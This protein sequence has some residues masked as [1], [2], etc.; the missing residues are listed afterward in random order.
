MKLAICFLKPYNDIPSDP[1]LWYVC[2]S[3]EHIST[4]GV[5]LTWLV[6]LCLR[7]SQYME[8]YHAAQL[9]LVMVLIHQ[10]ASRHD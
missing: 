1:F 4:T 8:V 9:D 7:Q 6:Q 10:L 2:L 5:L 3:Q